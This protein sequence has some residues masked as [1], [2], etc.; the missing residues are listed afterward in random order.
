[1]K[2]NPHSK[3]PDM[4]SASMHEVKRRGQPK[5]GMVSLGCPKA[6]V[7]SERILTRLREEGYGI[8]KEYDSADAV[9]V[10][11]CG[12]LDSAKAES[13][14]AIGEALNKNGR[15]VVTGCLGA[16]PGYINGAHPKVLAV[17][18]PNQYEQVLDAI[19][20]AVPPNPNPFLDLMPTTGV[21]LNTAAL[22][23][24]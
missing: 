20:S 3:C 13:L 21:K 9:I 18:G 14:D 16:D 5:I 17:T 22:Q 8:S 19:H 1:M 10:N 23:L 15:V 24:P 2:L 7:D 11:T 12:F 4:A 6:L